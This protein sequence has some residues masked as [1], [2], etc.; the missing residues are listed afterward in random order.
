M[1]QSVGMQEYV[2]SNDFANR[3][4]LLRFVLQHVGAGYFLN[5]SLVC[6]AW[7]ECY[8]LDVEH[9]SARPVTFI[10]P[11]L[12]SPVLWASVKEHK[13]IPA[14]AIG[15]Y[16]C[17]AVLV[18]LIGL[19]YTAQLAA[20][21]RLQSLC[22]PEVPTELWSPVVWN[23]ATADFFKW[24]RKKK[25]M[26][27]LERAHTAFN[28]RAAV[29]TAAATATT[30]YSGQR[31]L[32]IAAGAAKGSR[33]VLFTDVLMKWRGTKAA[34]K[35]GIADVLAECAAKCKQATAFDAVMRACLAFNWIGCL[36]NV[37]ISDVETTISRIKV[38]HV[39]AACSTQC[40]KEQ[41]SIQQFASLCG[42][43]F[44]TP[45]WPI[46]FNMTLGRYCESALVAAVAR[47][48][49]PLIHLHF[50]E[51]Y[52]LSSRS[53]NN[54]KLV[55]RSASRGRTDV[56]DHLFEKGYLSRYRML[57]AVHAGA[58]EGDSIATV[59]WLQA[60]ALLYTEFINGLLPHRKLTVYFAELAIVRAV[61][62]ARDG[63]AAA[64]AAA[65]VV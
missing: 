48:G 65:A 43:E 20:H 39:A 34:L 63:I 21:K 31:L 49:T 55:Q 45:R 24:R 59:K 38:W 15:Q 17:D 32:R 29:D 47:C 37:N 5:I 36:N 62:L 18:E 2:A 64:A 16:A 12:L 46:G 35:D 52:Y 50:I 61:T 44:T 40:A 53:E 23:A 22:S 54:A 51:S 25:A 57:D 30:P 13:L 19:P 58:V 3:T 26:R 11:Y 60:H 28:S 27:A 14:E 41:L 7:K 1:Q 10:K 6:K 4:D 33:L 9:G 56:L 8:E 42:T